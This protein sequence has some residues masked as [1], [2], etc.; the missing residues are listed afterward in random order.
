MEVV[1]FHGLSLYSDIVIGWC[2][3]DLTRQNDDH[4]E[5]S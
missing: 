2:T 3:C 1:I 5:A 4:E